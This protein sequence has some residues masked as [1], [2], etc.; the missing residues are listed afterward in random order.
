ML[1]Y[2]GVGSNLGDR[3]K[4]LEQAREFLTQN[5]I[6]VTRASSYYE[7]KAVCKLGEVAPDF[8]NGVFEIETNLEPEALLDVLEKIEKQM[9]RKEKGSWAPRTIDL[10]ILFYGD[11]VI[12]SERL[13]IP[14]PDI[15]ERGFVLKPLS[16]LAPDMSHPLLKK[17][18]REM[19]SDC[20]T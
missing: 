16:D 5:D 17:S 4:N 15:A 12:E 9:G 6:L 13:T 7:T 2:I 3:Q 18:I 19:L 8:L 10:D 20:C 1:A 11:V 14:H